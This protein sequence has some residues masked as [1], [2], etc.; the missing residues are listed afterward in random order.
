MLLQ[1]WHDCAWV[2][3]RY[4]PEVLRPH[5]PAGF[6]LDLADGAAWVSLVSFRIPAMRAAQLPPVPGLRSGAESHLR[7]YVVDP[8]GRRGIWLLSLDID[9]LP[10]AL[11]GRS[12]LLPYWPAGISIRR[13]DN[14]VSYRVDRQSPGDVTLEMELEIQAEETDADDLDRFLTSRWVLYSGIGRMAAAIFTEHPPWIF[15]AVTVHG[16][17]QTM[18][19]RLGLPDPGVP[20]VH[21]SPGVA[22]RLSWPQPM[23]LSVPPPRPHRTTLVDLTGRDVAAEPPGDRLSPAREDQEALVDEASDASFPASDPPSYW[24]RST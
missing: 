22:A 1:D 2:H 17:Q 14:T 13:L 24:G 16:L 18:T 15:R 23:L 11:I 5:V 12:F 7:T 9:P 6:R 21:F 4:A 3:W 19:A 20:L 10:A 8:E